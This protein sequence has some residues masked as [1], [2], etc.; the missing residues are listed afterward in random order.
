MRLEREP[1]LER[2]ERQAANLN[3]IQKIKNQKLNEREAEMEAKVKRALVR[4]K[5]QDRVAQMNR[6]QRESA[7]TGAQAKVEEVQQM[8]ALRVEQRQAEAEMR[9]QRKQEAFEE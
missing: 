2:F 3:T 5:E 4:K 7:R 1:D 6:L 8:T 9:M